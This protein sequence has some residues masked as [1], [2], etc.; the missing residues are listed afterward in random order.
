MRINKRKELTPGIDS[1]ISMVAVIN[2]NF[3]I[4]EDSIAA[5]SGA[6]WHMKMFHTVFTNVDKHSSYII[7]MQM[8]M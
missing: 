1:R 8:H 3:A 6:Q 2:V 4:V 5:L 7:N